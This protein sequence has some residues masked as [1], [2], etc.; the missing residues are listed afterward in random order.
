MKYFITYFLFSLF[1]FAKNAS[2]PTAVELGLSDEDFYYLSA[3][4]GLV[5]GALFGWVILSFGVKK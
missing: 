2:D 1:L 5:C 4:A 3:Q